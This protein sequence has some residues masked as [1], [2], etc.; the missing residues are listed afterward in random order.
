MRLIRNIILIVVP[1]LFLISCENEDASKMNKVGQIYIYHSSFGMRNMEYNI[2]FIGKK[3]YKYIRNIDNTTERDSSLQ[4]DGYDDVIDLSD[5]K[6]QRFLKKA[7]K[8]GFLD[9]KEE[10]VDDQI[11]DGHQWGIIISFT[12]GRKHEIKGSNKY[13]STWDEMY[14]EFE[15]LTGTNLLLLRSDWMKEQSK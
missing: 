9:W 15:T 3:F 5:K 14:S 1:F 4:N 2:D 8:Y 10:Y 6:I 7:N 12:D 13:P 11:S